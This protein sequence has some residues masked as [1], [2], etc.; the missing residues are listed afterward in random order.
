[1]FHANLW[2]T[3]G[4]PSPLFYFWK[5]IAEGIKDEI[6]YVSYNP[7]NPLKRYGFIKCALI[8]A[9][10]K[11]ST[12]PKTNVTIANGPFQNVSPMKN[13]VF[14][15]PSSFSGRYSNSNLNLNGQPTT[16]V[17]PPSFHA[18]ASIAES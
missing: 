15:L 4:P 10:S 11:P 1:M 6:F 16:A 3:F 18:A 8:Y 17:S 5:V 9:T 7:G 2:Q 14:P 13:G 12:P